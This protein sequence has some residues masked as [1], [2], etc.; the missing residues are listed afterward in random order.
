MQLTVPAG[1][2]TLSD[3]SGSTL[4]YATASTVDFLDFE[5]ALYGTKSVATN[6]T[7]KAM[8]W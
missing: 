6:C 4:V 5:G 8:A 3:A 1:T 7:T 2:L